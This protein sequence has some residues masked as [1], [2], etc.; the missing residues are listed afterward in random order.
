M[1]LPVIIAI[2]LAFLSNFIVYLLGKL[3]ID[4]KINTT[5]NNIYSID[6]NVER[7]VS[8]KRKDR[9]IRIMS[10]RISR[11]RNTLFK[12]NMYK[13]ISLVLLY[14]TILTIISDYI[15]GAVIIPIPNQVI[16]GK[17]GFL[18]IP[19]GA[20]LIFLIAFLSFLWLSIRPIGK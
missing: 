19:N 2:L 14:F 7:I 20:Y 4:K 10:R 18:T 3:Y 15:K 16:D 8:P 11:Y 17:P 12:Y 1:I 6:T 9:K 13:T 5:L